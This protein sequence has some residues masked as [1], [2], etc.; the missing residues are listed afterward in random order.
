LFN[1]FLLNPFLNSSQTREANV[2]IDNP[3]N[4]IELSDLDENGKLYWVDKSLR[5]LPREKC[6][7]L[8]KL[9]KQIISFDISRNLLR[10][11]DCSL[12]PLENCAEVFFFDFFFIFSKF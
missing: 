12:L 4:L 7:E 10:S 3:S 8:Y 5:L 6:A 2:S 11:V 1:L 9:N